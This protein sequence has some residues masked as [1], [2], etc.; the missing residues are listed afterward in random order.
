MDVMGYIWI[1]N[2]ELMGINEGGVYIYMYGYIRYINGYQ[3][4][5]RHYRLLQTTQDIRGIHWY[6]YNYIYIKV[7]QNYDNISVEFYGY[8]EPKK[9]R[10]RVKGPLLLYRPQETWE[11]AGPDFV[12]NGGTSKHI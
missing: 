8:Q 3:G 9:R 1:H 4:I 11:E 5:L 2:G 10:P 7:Y 6:L 12:R